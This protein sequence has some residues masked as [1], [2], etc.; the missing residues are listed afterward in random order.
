MYLQWQ[1][2]DR[3]KI[4]QVVY[5]WIEQSVWSELAP[6]TD[7]DRLTLSDVRHLLAFLYTFCCYRMWTTDRF[8]DLT[9]NR[10]EFRS[11]P[12]EATT[13]TFVSWTAERSGVSI[14]ATRAFV[15]LLSLDAGNF[16]A[17]VGNQP[18]V[19]SRSGV[20][21][22]LPRLLMQLN[23]PRMLAGAINKGSRE[24]VYSR[25]IG[26][27]EQTNLDVIEAVL[28]HKTPFEIA[29]EKGLRRPGEDPLTPDFLIFEPVANRLLIVDYKH[30]LV[31][32]SMADVDNKLDDFE[33]W[34]GKMPPVLRLGRT[35]PA[36]IAPHLAS[37]LPSNPPTVT[38]MILTRWPLPLPMNLEPDL[39]ITDWASLNRHLE[40]SQVS[41]ID[42]LVEWAKT[43]PDVQAPTSF[44]YR[45]MDVTVGEWTYRRM[46]LVT[47]APEPEEPAQ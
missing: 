23:F 4:V 24:Q 15:E 35:N 13:D 14:E 36:A 41:Q 43:R 40:G 44:Q 26:N 12:L 25:L 28:R 46:I 29:R 19:R 6:E 31:P 47:D 9:A 16:H 30:V 17:K 3:Q 7:F 10:G 34:R 33:E 18:I 45:P 11:Q 8:E 27:F 38:G 20:V 37:F 42:G 1:P 21:F 39:C 2:H 32:Y 5:K 22:L